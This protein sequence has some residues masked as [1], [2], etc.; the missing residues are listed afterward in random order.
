MQ[1]AIRLRDLDDLKTRLYTNITHEFRTPLTVIMGMNDNI[2]GHVQ[3]K[4]L[5]RRNAKNL[6]R[7]IN[8]LLDLSKLDSGT[9]KMD[10]VQ[11]DMIG[12]LQ[13]LTE[14]FYS[15]ASD[16]KVSL[17]FKPE[18]ASLIM[19]FDEV[20]MQHIIYNLLSNAIKFT[21]PGGKV[22]LETSQLTRNGQ[23]VLKIKVKDTG[24]GI[25]EKDLPH[26]FDRFYQVDK[27]GGTKINF[28]CRYGYWDWH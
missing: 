17:S 24:V 10:T 4:N 18:I 3:E 23:D 8:Q 20:K 5:I 12:Y 13:Y 2:K 27:K 16:K 1:E 21:R 9:L 25:A 6:L 14:S 28:H 15:M 7:L 26:I 11:G 19:D 22:A